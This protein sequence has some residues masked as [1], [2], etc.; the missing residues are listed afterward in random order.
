MFRV[1]RAGEEERYNTS[2]YANRPDSHRLLLWHGSH[3]T[4]YGGILSQ[5]LRIAPPE[6][7]VNGYMFGKGVYFADCSAKSAPFCYPRQTGFLGLLLLCEVDVGP[8]PMFEQERSN[9][10][11]AEE[12]RAAGKTTTLGMGSF[13]P[14]KWKDAGC[15]NEK[16]SGVQ[17]P[18]FS[19]NDGFAYSLNDSL[20]DGRHLLFNEYIAYDVRQIRVRY[21]LLTQITGT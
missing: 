1:S 11:A 13:T 5:G 21:L 15:I 16:L 17:M 7:P 20:I 12:S 2:P 6:A 19:Q 8:V 18:D 3:A 14:G 4:N 9:K 10:D